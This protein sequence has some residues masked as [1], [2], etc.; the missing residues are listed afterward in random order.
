LI[1]KTL[2]IRDKGT[3]IPALAVQLGPTCEADRWL[4]ARAGFGLSPTNQANYV[5]LVHLEGDESHYDPHAWSH[6]RTMPVAHSFIL[7]NFDR[8]EDGAV[9]DVEFIL[10]ESQVPKVSERLT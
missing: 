5:I 4:L 8:L 10:G 9:V 7:E 1:A 2:E 6:A 3:F